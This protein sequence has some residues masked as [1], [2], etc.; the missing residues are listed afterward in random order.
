MNLTK[1][2][3]CVFIHFGNMEYI[4]KYVEIYINELSLYFDEVIFVM[5]R[6]RLNTYHLL[7]LNKNITLKLVKNEGYDFGMF[8]KAFQQIVHSQYD[9]IA[10][11]N[12]S[13]VLFHKL[14]PIFE[15]DK[16]SNLD[17]WGLIDSNERPIFSTIR[18]IT[19]S[20]AIFLYSMK[21]PFN[22]FPHF[23]ILSI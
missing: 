17:F 1:K 21:K 7:L 18:I 16:S 8:Y 6:R 10:C 14:T 15:W 12:D 9:Q 5:N 3:L 23:S 22:C 2:S 11:I 13:N 19:I 20:K 4:P